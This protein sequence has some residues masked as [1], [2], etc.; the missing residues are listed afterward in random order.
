LRTLDGHT[1]GV[2]SVEFSPDGKRLASASFDKTVRVWD[3]TP[4]VDAPGL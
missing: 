2:L 3:V 4:W 1:A